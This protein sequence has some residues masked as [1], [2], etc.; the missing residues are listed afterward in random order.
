M[1]QMQYTRED[2]IRKWSKLILTDEWQTEQDVNHVQGPAKFQLCG[3]S[4]AFG[5]SAC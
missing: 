2:Y 1:L 4:K 3:S 5:S